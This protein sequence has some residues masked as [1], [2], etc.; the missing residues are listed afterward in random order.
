MF[1]AEV[2]PGTRSP[3]DSPQNSLQ[4]RRF[5]HPSPLPIAGA[6]QAHAEANVLG[7]LLASSRVIWSEG[8]RVGPPDLIAAAQPSDRSQGDSRKDIRAR[9]IGSQR[10]HAGTGCL[11]KG[12][13]GPIP[14][15][16][17][18]QPRPGPGA[19]PSLTT[20]PQWFSRRRGRQAR[21]RRL[22]RTPV[23]ARRRRGSPCPQWLNW[24][25]G[26]TTESTE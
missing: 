16:P 20:Q 22:V 7:S 17:R 19:L 9:G 26:E 10:H 3:N 5:P 12:F 1:T 11:I 25:S 21:P 13:P 18:S 4:G 23:L 14:T 8:E 15:S 24:I 2:M 6:E